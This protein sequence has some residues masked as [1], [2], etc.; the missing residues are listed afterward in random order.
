MI[1]GENIRYKAS[2]VAKPPN[3]E[4]Y[5]STEMPL[6]SN[7]K[8]GEVIPGAYLLHCVRSKK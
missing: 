2:N 1:L 6:P 4:F 5:N 3:V 7:D 8:F